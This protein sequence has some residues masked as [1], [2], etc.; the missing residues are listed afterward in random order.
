[1]THHAV[2]QR[3]RDPPHS[4]AVFSKEISR[5]TKLSVIGHCYRFFF[6]IKTEQRGN[7]GKTSL[8]AR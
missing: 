3:F 4:F 1:M 5:Q 8:P 2:L 6:C 7:E